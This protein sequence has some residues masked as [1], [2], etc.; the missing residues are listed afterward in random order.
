MMSA[1]LRKTS[2]Y[3]EERVSRDSG[4]WLNDHIAMELYEELT[5][6]IDVVATMLEPVILLRVSIIAEAMTAPR[7]LQGMLTGQRPPPFPTHHRMRISSAIKF[8]KSVRT[9]DA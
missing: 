6:L 4:M 2:I 9:S 7:E 8:C 3:S 5:E 1:F